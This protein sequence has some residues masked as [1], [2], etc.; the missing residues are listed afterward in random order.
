MACFGILSVLM[1]QDANWDLRNHRVYIGFQFHE[2][3]FLTD[4][5]AVGLQT[6]YNPLPDLFYY[7]VAFLL[8]P[9]DPKIVSFLMGFNHAVLAFVVIL[10]YRRV[11]AARQQ[12]PAFATA[13]AI[14]IGLS[15][16]I[17]ISELGTTFNDALPPAIALCGVLILLP[18]FE[19]GGNAE[20]GRY[21]RFLLAGALAGCAAGLK[22]TAMLFAPALVMAV[23]LVQGLR[24]RTFVSLVV[25][26]IGVGL[27]FVAT[28]G[29]WALK[30]YWL[31]GNPIFPLHNH[32]FQ[33]DWYPPIAFRDLRWRTRDWLQSVAYPFF[34]IRHNYLVVTEIP[35]ADAR[36]AAAY[37]A[38]AAILFAAGMA[39]A[40]R[41]NMEISRRIVSMPR[42]WWFV[43]VFV[44]FSYFIWQRT[45]AYLRYAIGIEVLVGIPILIAT[46]YLVRALAPQQ[47]RRP[48][49]NACMVTFAVALQ[50]TTVYPDW[51]RVPY[52]NTMYSVQAPPLPPNS[53]II[54][55]SGP[56]GYLA[57]FLR[58]DN[59]RFVG[60]H[61]TTLEARGYRLWTE[62]ARRISNHNGPLFVL[63]R[64]DGAGMRPALKELGVIVIDDACQP[65]ATNI[66]KGIRLCRA[67]RSGG[68]SG[69]KTS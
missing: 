48:L 8:F 36:F 7:Y 16:A 31:T 51:S 45:F 40:F 58:G 56:H 37:V 18:E 35:F 5:M 61:H 34:W 15:G 32:I 9:N 69:D 55:S 41:R 38:T 20:P 17:T 11:F 1:G 23:L 49:I 28:N 26:G 24:K 29:W 39:F 21:G 50:A 67:K 13:A 3:R 59:V 63:E 60:V 25:L 64:P 68:A 53:M 14:F 22:L 65:I 44:I 6:Y 27:G 54:V 46:Y 2:Q 43:L 66:D 52:G 19:R 42:T 12:I 30:V 33:S 57:P 62:T 47:W 4:F 10:I